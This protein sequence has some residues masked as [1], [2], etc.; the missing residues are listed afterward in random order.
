MSL[1]LSVTHRC[2]ARCATCRVTKRKPDELTFKEYE[3]IFK[4]LKG[5]IRWFTISGGEPFMRDDL[6]DIVDCL[7]RHN[8]PDAITIPTNG[9]FTQKSINLVKNVVRHN[10]DT[11]FIMSFSI[12]AIGP[13]HDKI[14]GLENSFEK[15][16]DSFQAVKEMDVENLSTG[17]HTV[18]SK[19]NHQMIPDLI[20]YLRNFNPDYHRFEIAQSRAELNVQNEEFA[21]TLEQYKKT[22]DFIKRIEDN[23]GDDSLSQIIRIF[24]N[25]YYNLSLKIIDKKDQVI[26]CF[27]G[28]A[29]AHIGP[30]GDVWPCCTLAK[31]MGNLREKS[32]SF[33]RVWESENATK[34]R[35]FIKENR[36]YCPMANACYTN[37]LLDAGLLSKIIARYLVKI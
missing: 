7:I 27:A 36:C 18:I 15:A 4:T 23:S 3:A 29:S 34:V 32:Y 33:K 13:I 20:E 31:P 10:P 37:M 25:E 21:P 11:R 26:P 19:Y 28:I 1:A 22:L 24:R 17:F 2:N 30:N 5:N 35:R 16:M 8:S 14:R 6:G 12:D 9:S